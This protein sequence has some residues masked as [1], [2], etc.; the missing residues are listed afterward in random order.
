MPCALARVESTLPAGAQLLVYWFRYHLPRQLVPRS[1]VLV[2][3]RCA[4]L[5]VESQAG[6]P[7]YKLSLRVSALLFVLSCT[8]LS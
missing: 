3:P 8:N 4:V 1:Q 5:A 2:P 6:K 7:A